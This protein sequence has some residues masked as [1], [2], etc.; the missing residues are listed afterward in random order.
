MKNGILVF[1][2][3][4]HAKCH[5]DVVFHANVTSMWGFIQMSLQNIKQNTKR[6]ES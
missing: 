2:C 3:H 5:V 4:R 1:V 6:E